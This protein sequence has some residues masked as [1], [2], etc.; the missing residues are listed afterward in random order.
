MTAYPIHNKEKL[1]QQIITYL[2]NRSNLHQRDFS[3]KTKQITEHTD[4][5]APPH[6][7][8]QIIKENYLGTLIK[9]I[10]HPSSGR[11]TVFKTQFWRHSV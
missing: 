3:F 2:W 4:I 10:N 8:T 1:R 5:D 11:S 7:L 9:Q 6:Y